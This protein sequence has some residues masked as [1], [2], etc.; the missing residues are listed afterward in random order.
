[1]TNEVQ[2]VR[3]IDLG[4][5]LPPTA[6][7]TRDVVDDTVVGLLEVVAGLVVTVGA[8]PLPLPRVLLPATVEVV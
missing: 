5:R 8:P 2:L 7:G 4:A 6:E 3:P 1:M